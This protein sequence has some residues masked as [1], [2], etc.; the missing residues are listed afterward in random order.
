MKDFDQIFEDVPLY[1]MGI[2]AAIGAIIGAIGGFQ[3]ANES[4]GF[5]AG[6]LFSFG[7]LLL[8]VIIGVITGAFVGKAG[9]FV[10]AISTVLIAPFII[11]FVKSDKG[12][13]GLCAFFGILFY[14]I[15]GL[16]LLIIWTWNW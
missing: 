16:V 12:D 8:G 9:Q 15:V 6:L 5:G 4:I 13:F 11:P 10:V 2:G 14:V 3:S 7:G 1:T